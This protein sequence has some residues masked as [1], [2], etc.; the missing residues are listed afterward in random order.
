ML[1]RAAVLVPTEKNRKKKDKKVNVI[2]TVD[3]TVSVEG[4]YR[5]LR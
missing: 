4:I 5:V 3:K 1:L 2:S